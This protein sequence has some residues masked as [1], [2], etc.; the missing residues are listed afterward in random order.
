MLIRLVKLALKDMLK[1]Q[2]IFVLVSSLPLLS[3]VLDALQPFLETSPPANLRSSMD[4]RQIAGGAD[5]DH[6]DVRGV[7]LALN[8]NAQKHFVQAHKIRVA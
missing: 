4:D 7:G 3:C 8:V 5:G 6:E 2:R 1:L